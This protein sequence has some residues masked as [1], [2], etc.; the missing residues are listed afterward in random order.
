MALFREDRKLSVDPRAPQRSHL[1]LS[2]LIPA[3]RPASVNDPA[4][5]ARFYT[6]KAG[7]NPLEIILT[8]VLFYLT[9]TLLV[10]G[11]AER[12]LDFP[13]L[14]APIVLGLSSLAA[15]LVI[16]SILPIAELVNQLIRRLG[17][18]PE[19][20]KI[21]SGVQQAILIL[22]CIA[23]ALD[24]HWVRWIGI[25]WLTLVGVEIIARL[26]EAARPGSEG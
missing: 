8:S 9:W 15:V 2:R 26:I 25:L 14:L 16:V 4:V 5:D 11:A 22:A 3:L 24:K 12:L 18:K 21:Q 20:V 19:G 17:W 13:L 6:S 23:A 10:Y 7:H 1:A